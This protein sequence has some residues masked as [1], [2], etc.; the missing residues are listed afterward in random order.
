MYSHLLT[1][2]YTIMAAIQHWLSGGDPYGRYLNR[3]GALVH[4]GAFAY[5][6]PT[7]LLGGLLSPLPWAVSG[8]LMLLVSLFGFEYWTRSTAGRTGL[9]WALLWLPICQGFYIGQTTLLTLVC[10]MGAELCYARKHDRWA[11]ALLALALLKPHI[12]VLPAAWLL[13]VALRERRWQSLLSFGLVSLALWGGAALI[14]GPTIYAH[15]LS[16]ISNYGPEL[17]TRSLLFPPLGPLLGLMAIA[18]WW[19]YGRGDVLGLLLLVNTLIYPLGVVYVAT[20][21][22]FVVIRWRRDWPFYPLALSW[23]V[24]AVVTTAR[25]PDTAAALTQAIVATG[26]LA[27]LC[28]AIP[29][30][31][32]LRLRGVPTRH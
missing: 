5:P 11:G 18:L 6:P 13:F 22:A 3:S 28:P 2:W 14:A 29:W 25:T 31:H 32:L 10:L 7:L 30:Q 26:L 4:A 19:R 20:G 1:D 21:L 12:I 24:A 16:A 15:W 17:A 8:V 23:V 9:F 27:G